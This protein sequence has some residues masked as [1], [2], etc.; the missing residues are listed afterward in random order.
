MGTIPSILHKLT[1][2]ILTMVLWDVVLLS[3]LYR[4]GKLSFIEVRLLVQG[5]Y[6]ANY[7]IELCMNPGSLV[8]EAIFLTTRP[9]CPVETIEPVL[10]KQYRRLLLQNGYLSWRVS[11]SDSSFHKVENL[12]WNR[13]QRLRSPAFGCTPLPLE[14]RCIG[15]FAAIHYF[16]GESVLVP[17]PGDLKWF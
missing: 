11:V 3:S 5:H 17:K 6:R 2:L 14:C 4:W 1:S 15:F 7:H 16:L 9:N 8:P 13:G 12:C 10:I